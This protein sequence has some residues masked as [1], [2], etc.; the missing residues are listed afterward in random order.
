MLLFYLLVSVLP[1]ARHPLWS[2][3]VGDLT[4]VK[5]VGI[6]SA[7]YAVVYLAVR[8]T[9]ARFFET[10]QARWFVL[11]AAAGMASYMAWG[12]PVYRLG[13]SPFFSFVSF[14]LFFFTTVAVVDSV[15]RLRLSLVVAVASVGFAS[16]HVIREWQKYG[17]FGD[18]RPGYVTGDAN[19]YS[20]SAL[21]T[22]PIAFYLLKARPRPWERWLCIAC[23]AVTLLGLT[24]AASRGGLLGLGVAIVWAAVQTRQRWR[25][26]GLAAVVMIPLLLASP[27]SPL[28][29]LVSPNL[30]DREAT[31][32]RL[33]AW[34]AG[35][36]MVT[37][38]PLTGVGVGNFQPLIGQYARPGEDVGTV[39]HNMYLEIAA[40]MGLPGLAI[41]VAI[42]WSAFRTLRRVRR[43]TRRDGPLILYQS[44]TGLEAGLIGFLAAC[45]FVSAQYQRLFWFAVF[46]TM[47][48]PS[49]V[50]REARRA[51]GPQPEPSVPIRPT[52]AGT[53][54]EPADTAVRA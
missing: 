27:S 12:I 44:A 40:E 21:I 25:L 13:I 17:G 26:L 33:A 31:D 20:L 45:F 51:R 41:F 4:V 48:L 53:R 2:A 38:E 1:L 11:F 46:L 42:L 16:L 8:T 10:A 37:A 15:K 28:R 43:Q 22:I 34:R 19:Y 3:F 54:G 50:R 24:A 35:L 52:P 30:S 14:L 6:G 18:Y 5:Y 47:V 9:R 23:L 49:L 36:S 29:R 32:N 39:A 7:A